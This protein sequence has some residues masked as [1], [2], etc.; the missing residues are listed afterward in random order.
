MTKR[1]RGTKV[2]FPAKLVCSVVRL[3]QLFISPLLPKT[4]RFYPSCSEYMIQAITQLG[5]A[6]GLA[7]GAWRILRCN[8]FC[9]GG[10]DP[11]LPE[12]GMRKRECGIENS[13]LL[14]PHS[15]LR[16]PQ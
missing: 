10:Y 5:L 15:T 6:R 2:L 12:C 4:C 14:T 9:A 8:P 16:T 13:G 11:V 7:K 3:Y 1:T